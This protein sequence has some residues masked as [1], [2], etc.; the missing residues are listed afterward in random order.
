MKRVHFRW[1]EPSFWRMVHA[2]M[3]TGFTPYS[4]RGGR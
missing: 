4:H 2:W 3:V 1:T